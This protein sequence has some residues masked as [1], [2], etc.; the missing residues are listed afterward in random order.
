MLVVIDVVLSVSIIKIAT[1]NRTNLC[2]IGF[3]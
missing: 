2:K 3:M 1:R